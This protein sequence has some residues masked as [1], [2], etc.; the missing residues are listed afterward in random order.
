RR[1]RPPGHG[2][3]AESGH[4]RPGRRRGAWAVGPPGVLRSRGRTI[5]PSR[6]AG[7]RPSTGR[8]EI[9]PPAH[10]IQTPTWDGAGPNP[11]LIA[12]RNRVNLVIHAAPTVLISVQARRPHR[13]CAQVLLRGYREA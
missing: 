13:S 5:G 7:P 12:P 2:V 6:P 11:A 10:H 8:A 9:G 4:R 1:R 3:R